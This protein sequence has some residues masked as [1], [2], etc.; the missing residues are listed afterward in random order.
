MVSIKRK[1]NKN[2]RKERDEHSSVSE[3]SRDACLSGLLV[4]IFL[5]T[6]DQK[7]KRLIGVKRGEKT[8]PRDEARKIKV[9]SKRFC[10]IS[11]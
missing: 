2:E 6:K 10:K 4:N 8:S 9:C 3:A 11:A 5:K 1:S 7:V